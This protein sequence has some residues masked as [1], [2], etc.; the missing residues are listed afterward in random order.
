MKFT[1]L[2]KYWMCSVLVLSCCL[3]TQANE[4]SNIEQNSSN[5][6]FSMTSYVQQLSEQI[7]NQFQQNDQNIKMP[8]LAISAAAPSSDNSMSN[9]S[10]QELVRW[11]F[12]NCF[13]QIGSSSEFDYS[14]LRA[15]VR[16]FGGCS[17][18]SATN[19]FRNS[20]SHSCTPGLNGS[21]ALCVGTGNTC[22]FSNNDAF[23][24][25]FEVT[26]SP[27]SG[28]TATLSRLSFYEK[29]PTHFN[30]INGSS[31]LNNYPTRYGV[32]VTKNGQQIF[33]RVDQSTTQSYSLESFNFSNDADFTVSTTT[34]F[35]FELRAYCRINNGA[36]RA[37]WD[38]EDIKVFGCCGA[39]DPLRR[40]RRRC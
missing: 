13:S 23:A 29:A 25:R 30:F 17:H 12:N 38:L 16:S 10:E 2:F 3:F 6:V 21:A 18:I 4:N 5:A 9:C 31:G 36:S 37:V 33:K 22:T 11:N 35:K 1:S 14:E 32:R 7:Q 19:V 27:G 28:Q 20:G 40:T 8:H 24:V 39:P 15:S 34:T 26:L